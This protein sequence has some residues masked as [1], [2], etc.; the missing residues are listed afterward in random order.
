MHV[1]HMD[2]LRL[3]F[4][5]ES[6]ILLRPSQTEPLIRVYAEAQTIEMRDE[7]L[8]AGIDLAHGEFT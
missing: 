2:G 3:E 5:D 8:D 4:D 1:S 7:L 6:W